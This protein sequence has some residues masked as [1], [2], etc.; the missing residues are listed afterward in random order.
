MARIEKLMLLM[1]SRKC[2][3]AGELFVGGGIICKDIIIDERER[4]WVGGSTLG[5]LSVERR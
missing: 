3:S 5:T 1:T 2:Q 4:E